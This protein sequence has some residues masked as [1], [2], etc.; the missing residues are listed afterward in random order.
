MSNTEIGI[1]NF[2]T[3][4]PHSIGFDQSIAHAREMMSELRVRHLPVLKGGKLIGILSDR[5]I[6]LVLTF[7]SPS[8]VQMKVEEAC[9]EMPYTVAPD[10][11]LRDVAG[12]MAEKKIGS[13][14]V[15]EDNKVVG[16]FTDVDA[17]RVLSSMLQ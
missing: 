14:I 13:A 3:C 9:T 1:E 6:C 17:M 12:V 7:E 10:T 8:A 2:M 5:D 16:I 11:P 4:Q 15:V